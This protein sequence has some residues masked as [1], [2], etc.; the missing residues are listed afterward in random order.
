MDDV[1]SDWNSE[2]DQKQNGG[3]GKPNEKGKEKED[4]KEN[5]PSHTNKVTNLDEPEPEEGDK[6]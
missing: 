1:L 2:Q 5:A 4:K 6:K 3:A